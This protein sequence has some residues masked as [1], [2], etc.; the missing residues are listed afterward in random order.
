MEIK[1]QT[2]P[3]VKAAKAGDIVVFDNGQIVLV[4]I[5]AQ[6][7]DLCG[8]SMDGQGTIPPNDYAGIPDDKGVTYSADKYLLVMESK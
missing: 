1:V 5:D 4:G 3:G 7:G 8:Y 2:L 6:S